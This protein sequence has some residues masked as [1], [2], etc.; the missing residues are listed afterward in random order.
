[1]DWL[2]EDVAALAQR[3]SPQPTSASSDVARFLLIGTAI[4][5]VGDGDKTPGVLPE[6]ECDRHWLDVVPVPPGG[7]VTMVMDLAVVD[8]A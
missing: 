3:W 8:P 6:L 2:A 4:A 5:A 1:V 7:L